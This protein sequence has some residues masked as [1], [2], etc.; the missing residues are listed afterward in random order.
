MSRRIPRI[1]T[2]PAIAALF[3]GGAA[4]AATGSNSF[5]PQLG[6]ERPTETVIIDG[7]NP[8]SVTLMREGGNQLGKPV[9]RIGLSCWHG[10][11]HGVTLRPTCRRPMSARPAPFKL[12]ERA[13][14]SPSRRAH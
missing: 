6:A 5:T 4:A 8:Q 1:I 13:V 11:H 12:S 2:V 10:V 9:H 3:V 14:R 7:L